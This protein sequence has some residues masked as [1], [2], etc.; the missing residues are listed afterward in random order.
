MKIYLI[1]TNDDWGYD[2]YDSIVVIAENKEKAIAYAKEECYNF[3][4]NLTVR[5][6]GIAHNNQGEG[7]VLASFNAG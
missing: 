2:D 1:S 7:R 6:I 3:S 4:D 5:E